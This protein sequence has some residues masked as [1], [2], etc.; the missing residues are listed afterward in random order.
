[1]RR[2]KILFI[3]DNPL[4]VELLVRHIKKSDFD[5]E[6]EVTESLS[7]IEKLISKNSFD[8]VICDFKL[9]GFSGI[10]AIKMIQETEI[11]IPV[12]LASGTI[13]DEKP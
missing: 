5:L 8:L 7:E 13:P 9:P 3:E 12:I 6:Y 1:M 2:I 4:D 10:D 11:D